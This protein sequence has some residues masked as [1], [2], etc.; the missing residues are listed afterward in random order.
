MDFD[1]DHLVRNP[2]AI[3]GLGGLV[4]LK[5]APGATLL[6]RAFNVSCGALLAGFLASAVAEYLSLRTDSMQGAV[7]FLI[8]V[9]GMNLVAAA[10]RVIR[11]V[12]LSDLLPW[13]RKE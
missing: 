1:P 13:L 5:F 8:G 10:V 12:K 6:E 11:D 3:G 4:S 7:A 2:F 9:F